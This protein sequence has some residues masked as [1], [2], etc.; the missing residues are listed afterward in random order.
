VLE[1]NA[2]SKISGHGNYTRVGP[3]SISLWRKM[4]YLVV[5]V[6]EG[7]GGGGIVRQLQDDY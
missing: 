6:W 1:I 5:C 4:E 3:C 7:G 2:N